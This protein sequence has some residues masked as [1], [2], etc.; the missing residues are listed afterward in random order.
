MSDERKDSAI[1]LRQ[2]ERVLAVRGPAREAPPAPDRV[3]GEP[4]S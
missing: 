1:S 2:T 3:R 4:R